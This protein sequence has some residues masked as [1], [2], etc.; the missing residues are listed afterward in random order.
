MPLLIAHNGRAFDI[1]FL[2]LELQRNGLALPETTLFFDT[3]RYAKEVLPLLKRDLASYSQVCT[4]P[5]RHCS[6]SWLVFQGTTLRKLSYEYL[7]VSW[8][9]L[10]LRR[11]WVL[12]MLQDSLRQHFGI[13]QSAQ[14]HRAGQDVKVLVEIVKG[15]LQLEVHSSLEEAVEVSLKK[16]AA[17]AQ[18]YSAALRK[19]TGVPLDSSV[20]S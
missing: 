8:L 14:A 18:H 11:D 13:P 4:A 19:R 3:Y 10:H 17:Y 9:M 6:L 1:P 2:H 12:C 7:I 15:L 16:E 20:S 5:A